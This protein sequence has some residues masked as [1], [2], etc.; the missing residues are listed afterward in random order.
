[1]PWTPKNATQHTKKADTGAKQALWSEVANEVLKRTGDEAQAVR[2]ANA[3]VR[4]KK[5]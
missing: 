2:T 5:K 4:G 1:M 3:V